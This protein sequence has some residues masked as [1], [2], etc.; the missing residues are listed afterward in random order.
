MDQVA[1]FIRE[2]PRAYRYHLECADFRLQS[3]SELYQ[4]LHSEL[5]ARAGNKPA[6]FEVSQGSSE[7][8][9]SIGTPNHSWSRC[10]S[11]SWPLVTCIRT[12][13]ILLC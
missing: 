11:R 1:W 12:L 3:I 7:S 8:A 13:G 5:A 6:L 9:E 10:A 4:E 2:Y